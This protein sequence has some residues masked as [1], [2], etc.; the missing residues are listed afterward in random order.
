MG[1]VSSLEGIYFDQNL[2]RE[3]LNQEPYCRFKIS[4]NWMS[5]FA[6]LRILGFWRKSDQRSLHRN[7]QSIPKEWVPSKIQEPERWDDI[8]QET[9]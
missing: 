8:H 5:D 4:V 7:Y 1:Y 6:S 9:K 2:P 3:S